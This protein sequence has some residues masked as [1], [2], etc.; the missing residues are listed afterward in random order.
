MILKQ[1][2]VFEGGAIITK[3]KFLG[4]LV[5]VLLLK[6]NLSPKVRGRGVY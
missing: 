4:V 1:I 3:G 6:L 5:E 2:Y